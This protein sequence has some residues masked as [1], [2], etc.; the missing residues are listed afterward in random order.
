MISKFRTLSLA[1]VLAAIVSI[2]ASAQTPAARPATPAATPAATSATLPD[3]KFAVVYTDQ[4]LNPKGGINKLVAAYG[5]LEREFKPRTDDLSTKQKT[6][7]DMVTK[8]QSTANVS[9]PAA[10]QKQREDAEQ[11]QLALKRASEDYERS[12]QKRQGEM[13]APLSENINQAL[14]VFARQRGITLLFDGAKLG[15]VMIVLNNQMDITDAFIA[16]YNAK[17]PAT[18]AAATTPARR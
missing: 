6:L 3:G 9:D 18:A 1:A 17:N 12:V 8:I 15:G 14:Q 13:L 10:L 11:L 2:S 4:F 5:A 16:D 7:Q